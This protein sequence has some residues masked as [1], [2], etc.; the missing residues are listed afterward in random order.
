MFLQL[1]L[2]FSILKRTF[3]DMDPY[4]TGYLL[5][6]EFEEVLGELCPELNKPEM[7]AI[8]AKYE[9]PADGRINFIEFLEPY[10]PRRGGGM[11]AGGGGGGGGGSGSDSY[12]ERLSEAGSESS[13]DIHD[14]LTMKLRNK[15]SNLLFFVFFSLL[16]YAKL[17]A[18]TKQKA[19]TKL[20]R[21]EEVVQAPRLQ[22]DGL[23]ERGRLQG[24][25]RLDQAEAQR[26]GDV[27]PAAAARRPARRLHK[28]QSFH[29]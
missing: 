29:K 21:L 19:F 28:L 3:Q 12:R 4:Y 15:V 6:E 20:P 7:D 8:C 27:H 16:S 5:R 11:A 13:R 26:R 24:D 1:I 17:N 10:G 23:R 9:N 18:K 25:T 2:Q 22:A 14:T